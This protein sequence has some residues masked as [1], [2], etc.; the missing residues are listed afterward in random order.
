[1]TTPLPLKRADLLQQGLFIGNSFASPEGQNRFDVRNPASGALLAQVV[2]ATRA[3][4][5]AAIEAADK[6][7]PSWRRTTGRER[8]RMLRK[9]FDLIVKNADDLA[10]LMTLEQGKPLAE[11][12][13]E[14][15]YGASF[16]EWFAE[17]AKRV[18]G[19][20]LASPQR[21]K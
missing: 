21:D 11:A 9:W 15:L 1:M 18:E 5:Q 19:S 7:L 3:D 6:A 12:K 14:V 8:S 10:T 20:L 16:I 2:S 17:E 4:A 13:G